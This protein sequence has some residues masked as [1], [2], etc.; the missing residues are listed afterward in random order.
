[1]LK[2]QMFFNQ[3][4]KSNV[5]MMTV[6]IMLAYLSKLIPLEVG[7]NLLI[8][9]TTI[10]GGIPL[11]I[12]V[13]EALRFKLISIELLVSIAV[14]SAVIIGEYSEAGIVVWLF[15]LG[16]LLEEV[17][18]NKTR[19]SI[20]DIVKMAPQTAIKVIYNSQ[21][22]YIKVD[23]DEIEKCDHLQVKTG[24]QIPVDGFVI[25]G[26][27]Y[28]DEANITGE[29]KL[30]HKHPGSQVFAG[31]ILEN[32]S[33][34]ISAQKIGE[35]ST[36][37]K[38]IE[39]VEEAQ[40]SQTDT[41]KF[42]D[43]FSQYYTPFV[44]V[45]AVIVGLVTRNFKLAITVLVLGCPGALVIGVPVSTVAGIGSAAKQGIIVK[46]SAI[47]DELRKVDT[48]VFD[49]TGTL[50]TGQPTVTKIDLINGDLEDN[51]KLLTSIE[52][53]SDHPLAKAIL[54]YYRQPAFLP[55]AA[56]EVIKGQGIKA[57]INGQQVL[58]GNQQLLTE[59]MIS[60]TNVAHDDHASQVLMAVD[61]QLRLAIEI[62]DSL[63]PGVAQTLKSLRKMNKNYRFIL[64]SGGDQTVAEQIVQ[65]L[66][67]TEVHG[68]F[69]PTDKAEF[70]KKLQAGGH[71]VAF[72]GDGINDS[73]ALAAANS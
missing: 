20:R 50:T 45:L 37:G 62:K 14:V 5:I 29:S 25:S 22:R 64:H 24:S 63:R 54:N 13:V 70:I 27:G 56:I 53:E 16:Y 34:I 41:Q 2:L 69:L 4:K 59:N 8:I 1:M 31:T 49:K 47:F 43:R 42:I 23:V 39:L 30:R 15:S 65:N 6:F 18:L 21:I 73:P 38:L 17:T 33:L 68:N 72:V 19:K 26:D 55:V 44:L 32:G 9:L 46:G 36:F 10:I 48:F 11:V 61:G 71:H 40:D 12:R 51:L 3:H 67:F 58:V 7:F 60:T 66:D 35:D 28:A 57:T 52:H